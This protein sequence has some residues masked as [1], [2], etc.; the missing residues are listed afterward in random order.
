MTRHWR[1]FGSKDPKI[2][3]RRECAA[4]TNELAL[5]LDICPL[6]RQRQHKREEALHQMIRLHRD[7]AQRLIPLLTIRSA[8][9]TF[10]QF[11]KYF[12][13]PNSTWGIT[14][15]WKGALDEWLTSD[16]GLH[17]L[18]S[19][20]S[21]THLHWLHSQLCSN[22]YNNSTQTPLSL[23][24]DGAGIYVLTAFWLL[25]GVHRASNVLPCYWIIL[26]PKREFNAEGAAHPGKTLRIKCSH[27]PSMDAIWC[28]T[29]YFLSILVS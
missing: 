8:A 15:E 13:G 28:A 25:K 5:F 18:N 10:L 26:T 17:P 16:V 3:R 14:V 27:M 22:A 6:W 23:V 29:I 1:C 24:S 7:G 11:V 2:S 21:A 19:C 9:I 12:S 4:I 20:F